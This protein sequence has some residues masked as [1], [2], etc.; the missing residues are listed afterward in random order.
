MWINL[1]GRARRKQAGGQLASTAAGE[2]RWWFAL[3]DGGRSLGI[4]GG[5]YR[6][7]VPALAGLSAGA[8]KCGDRPD[9]NRLYWIS[10]W[11]AA[12]AC[13]QVSPALSAPAG[14]RV[15]E[16][17]SHPSFGQLRIGPSS[18]L[19][20][21]VQSVFREQQVNRLLTKGLRRRVDV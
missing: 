19:S 16:G 4:G 12:A 5:W 8:N 11:E 15:S 20:A 17:P 1:L 14:G 13:G 9:G 7:D 3:A 6:G 10:V 18:K 21:S 2:F